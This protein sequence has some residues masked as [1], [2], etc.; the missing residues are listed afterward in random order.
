[1]SGEPRN[2]DLALALSHSYRTPGLGAGLLWI[3]V[4]AAA[5]EH[6]QQMGRAA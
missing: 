4:H 3:F 6:L 2:K 5:L 1:M